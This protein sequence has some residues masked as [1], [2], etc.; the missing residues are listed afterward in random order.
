MA[1]IK[2]ADRLVFSGPVMFLEGEVF[3][4]DVPNG[5]FITSSGPV[6]TKKWDGWNKGHWSI[7]VTVVPRPGKLCYLLS[8]CAHGLRD[9][10]IRHGCTHGVHSTVYTVQYERI[11]NTV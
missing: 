5:G 8:V 2:L 7:L 3:L 11:R 1:G 6:D 9:P 10:C 4:L